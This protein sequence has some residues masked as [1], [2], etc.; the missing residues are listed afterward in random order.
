MLLAVF[1][2]VL[3]RVCRAVQK[4]ERRGD[5]REKTVVEPNLT[6]VRI[7]ENVGNSNRGGGSRRNN[8]CERFSLSPAKENAPV[9]VLHHQHGGLVVERP[10]FAKLLNDRSA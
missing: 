1:D 6:V 9:A 4:R 3:D 5:E 8:F 10:A 7:F 2:A